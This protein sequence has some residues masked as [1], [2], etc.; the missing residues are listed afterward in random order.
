MFQ[1]NKNQEPEQEQNK[2]SSR[3]VMSGHFFIIFLLTIFVVQLFT[4]QLGSS[5]MTIPYSDFLTYVREGN[6][7][8]LT[9][10]GQKITGEFTEPVENPDAKEAP[11]WFPL[12]A[13]EATTTADAFTTT[14]PSIGDDRLLPL[15]E[16]HGV[17]VTPVEQQQSL[18]LNLLFSFGPVLLI[19][20]AV[21]Y[22]MR[23]QA[24]KQSGIFSFGQSRAKQ[25]SIDKPTVK[26]SDVA[27]AEE[28]K[29]ELVEVVDFLKH[30]ERYKQLGAKIPR[31]V[32]LVG[33]PGTGKTL[34]AR[35]IAGEA[36]V[37]FFSTSA[38]EFVEMFVGVGAS[39]VRDLFDQA[40]RNAPAIIFIDELDAVGRQRGAG[41]GGGH[42][43]REQTLNQILVQLDGF[44]ESTN[45][46][47]IAATNRPDVLDPAL[48]RPGR[49]D[50]QVTV[51]LPDVRGREAILNT[52]LR[53]K[54]V[55]SEVDPSVLARQTPG[56]AGANLANLVN[57]AAL[58]AAR[59]NDKLIAM[60]HFREALEKILLGTERPLLMTE[61]DRK[62]IAYHEAGHALVSIMM[63]ESDPVNRVT[64][65]PRGRSLGVTE[66]L[67][68]GDRYNYSRKYLMTQLAS[69]LGGRAAEQVAIGEVTTGAENDLQRATQIARRM[70]GRWGMSDELGLLFAS[71]GSNENPFLGREMTGA[72]DHS[73][74]TAALVDETVRSLLEER[75]ETT[76]KLLQENRQSLER[77]AQALLK[78]ETLDSKGI[79]AAIR[80]DEDVPPPEPPEVPPSSDTSER[81]DEEKPVVKKLPRVLPI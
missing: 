16:E 43:E 30:P 75:M 18:L 56:F 8:R 12:K 7:A 27:G 71:D 55:L 59:S 29:R 62:V 36:G 66:Y 41:F 52:H 26:F 76:V 9:M 17:Q 5:S 58:H 51:G 46:I 72:R 19:I 70:V 73:E 81:Q 49:F 60:K 39:R 6:V 13:K 37:Q 1:N 40:Q 24:G 45:V 42:D 79:Y 63:P 3:W 21:I 20:A 31:G 33:S 74:A 2:K 22:F 69:L 68:D 23:Q 65:I 80:G 64:I 53:G 67:P 38:S 25:H 34:L 47:V 44:E 50:R 61:Q 57:E 32:L 54:P 14:L 35:A 15:L 11:D 10:E 28:A 78:H 48:L 4:L 77:L